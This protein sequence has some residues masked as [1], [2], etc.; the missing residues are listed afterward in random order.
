[1]IRARPIRDPNAHKND[2]PLAMM[3]QLRVTMVQQGAEAPE[4][5]LAD[6]VGGHYVAPLTREEAASLLAALAGAMA[7]GGQS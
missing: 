3:R 6:G 4:L 2:P 7:G 5:V 1:M